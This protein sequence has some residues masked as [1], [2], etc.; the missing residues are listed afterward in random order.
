MLKH[1][2][3][4][5]VYAERNFQSAMDLE[6]RLYIASAIER[7][8]MIDKE[9]LREEHQLITDKIGRETLP[10]DWDHLDNLAH[11]L[12]YLSLIRDFIERFG[13]SPERLLKKRRAK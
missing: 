8:N 4:L 12:R 11:E 7:L 9:I 3:D 6:D 2:H 10:I 1:Y 13:I 5:K